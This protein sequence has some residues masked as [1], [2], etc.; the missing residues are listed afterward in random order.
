MRGKVLTCRQTPGPETVERSERE[1][2][3]QQAENVGPKATHG[4]AQTLRE[5]G[6]R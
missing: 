1:R 6:E 5:G 4:G 3:R 2:D